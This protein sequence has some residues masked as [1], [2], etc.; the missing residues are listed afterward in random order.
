MNKA[1]WTAAVCSAVLLGIAAQAQT[2]QTSD[3]TPAPPLQRRDPNVATLTATARA[4]VLDVVVTDAKGNPIKGLKRSD[5]VVQ[6]DGAPQTL[7][8]FEEHDATVDASAARQQALPKLPPNTFTNF[9][10]VPNR[11]SNTVILL[12][13]LDSPLSAQM[14]LRQQVI[15]YMKTVQPGTSIAVFQLDTEM[16]LIQG[17]SA[18]PKVLLAAVESKRDMPTIP[19][20]MGRNYVYQRSR[21]EILINGLQMMGRY[22]E[23][24]PGRKNLI[25]FTGS[26]PFAAYGDGIG[27]PFPDFDLFSDFNSILTQATDVLALSRVAVYP[28][29]TRGLETN[30]AFSAARR[31]PP[32]LGAMAPTH[33]FLHADMDDAADATGGKAYYNTNGLKNV[34]GQIVDGGSNY[35]TIAYTP[36]NKNW[37]GQFRKIKVTLADGGG[38]LLYRHG[39]FARA[40]AA[41]R[42]TPTTSNKLTGAYDPQSALSHPG[43]KQGFE[44]SMA[45]GAI[46]PTELI[47]NTNIAADSEVQKLQKNE[48]L[49]PNNYLRA[50][51]QRKPFR[52][53]HVLYAVDPHKIS[54]TR[55]PNGM[56]H[57]RLEFV[58]VVYNNEGETVN[59]I[60]TTSPL[61]LDNAAYRQLMQFGIGLRQTIAVPEKGNFFFRLGVH[62]TIGDRAGAVEV[63]VDNVQL[64]V[65]AFTAKPTP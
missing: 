65:A 63:P 42:V 30:P 50:D 23:G 64:G 44:V 28:V 6:E 9:T 15:D 38:Q 59:S 47:F 26:I 24:F 40:G 58:A 21:Q 48:P 45:L 1:L 37:N 31:G 46:P 33:F 43:M 25:W 32:P 10:P 49:P 7:D 36:T 19:P 52:N 56:H 2:P 39:Y 34:I 18:D 4:V 35:Y 17:F 20:L 8:S 22:L 41:H 27:D 61:E 29:D 14:Y 16:H 5:L 60:I 57:G 12:D 54:F 62:D 55:T 53:Y 3:D 51:F 13:A 11:G